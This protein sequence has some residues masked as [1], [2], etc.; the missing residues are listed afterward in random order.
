MTLTPTRH[1]NALERP[2]RA[3]LK[4]LHHEDG[5]NLKEIARHLGVSYP[6][7]KR[8]FYDEDIPRRMGRPRTAKRLQP[9]PATPPPKPRAAPVKAPPSEELRRLYQDEGLP[10]SAIAARFGTH[11]KSVWRWMARAGIERRPRGRSEEA[12]PMPEVLPAHIP[13]PAPFPEPGKRRQGART[14]V[15]PW[16]R[17][18]DAERRIVQRNVDDFLVYAAMRKEVRA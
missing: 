9:S 10:I 12:P 14:P 17:L 6:T 11:K 5:L 1:A 3:E 7:V 13:D 16:L 4:R 8:W 15:R 18:S 2:P